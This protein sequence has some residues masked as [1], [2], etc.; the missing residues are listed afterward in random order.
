MN[1]DQ[2][3]LFLIEDQDEEITFWTTQPPFQKGERLVAT[4]M[5]DLPLKEGW[6]SKGRHYLSETDIESIK[7][8]LE[9]R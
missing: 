5:F 1:K 4:R 3:K 9:K 2:I 8:E 7:E 6:Y